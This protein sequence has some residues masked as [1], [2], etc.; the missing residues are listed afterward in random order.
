MHA[1]IMVAFIS[2][3]RVTAGAVAGEKE[4]TASITWIEALVV[5]MY[6]PVVNEAK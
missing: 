6:C 2:A 1:G 4:P 5:V 3:L